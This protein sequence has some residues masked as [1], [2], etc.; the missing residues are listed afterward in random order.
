MSPA[1]AL[2]PALPMTPRRRV[3]EPAGTCRVCGCIDEHACPGG[4]A[5]V[6]DSLCSACHGPDHPTRRQAAELARIEDRQGPLMVRS[7]PLPG[8]LEAVLIG[9]EEDQQTRREHGFLAA[10]L[11]LDTRGHVVNRD[12]V[13]A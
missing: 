6:D 7:S 10:M 5:W 3:V 4:C 2:P 11:V 13:H 1:V 12:R 9:S 8:C